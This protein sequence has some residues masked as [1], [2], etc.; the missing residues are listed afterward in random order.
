MTY[1]CR[2]LIERTTPFKSLFW[3]PHNSTLKTQQLQNSTLNKDKSILSM[4]PN[5]NQSGFTFACFDPIKSMVTRIQSFYNHQI[6]RET[7]KLDTEAIVFDGELIISP[8]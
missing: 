5:Q 1:W 4:S 7:F 3:Y 8:K 2:Q 6:L